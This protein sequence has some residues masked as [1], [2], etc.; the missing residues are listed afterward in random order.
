MVYNSKGTANYL[1][2]SFKTMSLQWSLDGCSIF[3]AMVKIEGFNGLQ[4]V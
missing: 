4:M 1:G 3:N 2:K